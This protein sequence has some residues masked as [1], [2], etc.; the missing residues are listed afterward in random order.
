MGNIGGKAIQAEQWGSTFKQLGLP[1]YQV[2]QDEE[3]N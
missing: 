1:K 2:S 3:K